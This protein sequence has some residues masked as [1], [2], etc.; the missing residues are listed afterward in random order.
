VLT[1]LSNLPHRAQVLLFL[2]LSL[3][4][5]GGL[6][7][8]AITASTNSLTKEV[9]RNLLATS[10]I[11]ADNVRKEM[12]GL[13][14]VTSSFAS[15]PFLISALGHGRRARY[16]RRDIRFNLQQLLSLR[17]GIGTAF[18]ADPAGRLIDIVPAS[19]AIVGKSF[20]FRDWYKGV[21]RTNR[22][23]VSEVYRS[24]ATGHP[25]VVGVA[26]PI[27]D[28]PAPGAK[29]LGILVVGYRVAAIGRL[30]QRSGDA[31]HLKLTVTDQRGVGLAQ[32]GPGSGDPRIRA[33][34]AGRSGVTE[35]G[36]EGRRVLAAHAPVEGLGW[37]V[38]TE[39]LSAS[40]LADVHR[41]RTFVL[42]VS[43][44]F[45]L[46]LV[47][48][49]ALLNLALRERHRAVA[50]A[51]AASQAKSDFLAN[52]SHEIRTP[53]NGVIGMT[54][55][56]MSTHLDR[57][58]REYAA[59]ARRSGEALLSV[60][61]EILDFSKIEAGKLEL[62]LEPF[63]L[64]E[65][66]A[67]VCD[68]TAAR[69][70][71]K[72][73]ELA[74]AI[75]DCVPRRVRGDRGRLSQVLTNLLTNAVKFTAEGEVVLRVCC[76]EGPREPP[77]VRFEVSDTGIGLNERQRGRIFDSFTQ[78]DASTT[79]RFGGTGLGL[80]ISRDIVQEMGGEIGV[81]SEPGT[82]STFWLNVPLERAGDVP[83]TH[84]GD[85]LRGMRVLIVDDNRTNREILMRQVEALGM[86]SEV[87]ARGREALEVATHASESGEPFDLAIL[88]MHMPEMDGIE[89]ARRM[90]RDPA[91]RAIR[92]IMLTSG[93]IA[94]VAPD[95]GIRRRLRKPVRQSKLFDTI[96]EVVVGG[97]SVADL[98][99]PDPAEAAPVLPAAGA[100]RIL[101]VEDNEVNQSV[102]VA[103]LSRRGYA[104]DVAANG[105]EALDALDEETYDVVLMDCQMPVLDG[106]AATRELRR[107]E[108]AE[109]H[110]PVIAMTANVLAGEREK[111]LEAGMDDYLSKP[112]RSELLQQVLVAHLGDRP[113][114]GGAAAQA[115]HPSRPGAGPVDVERVRD[116]V[117]GFKGSDG[118][119]VVQSVVALY[120]EQAPQRLDA[121]VRAA[122]DGDAEALRTAAHALRGSSSALGAVEVEGLCAELER[123][124]A[125]GDLDRVVGLAGQ[126]ED[127][128][129]RTVPAL[130]AALAEV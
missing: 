43:V 106:Y 34:L 90:Q 84:D 28:G 110:T 3:G 85:A 128:V 73:L 65:A 14:D 71:D 80:T 103:M 126:L 92:L 61:D 81:D 42:V 58:Q 69:A 48:G 2:V 112:L 117:A 70:G 130:R 24:A 93:Q 22:P 45:A 20:A 18:V 116:L 74:L 79:R 50:Q 88:D 124:A 107:R 120:V 23:Y 21:R 59:I 94:P 121:V 78:A 64:H 35:T 108:G 127:A 44:L 47:L 89:L 129:A 12:Q 40:A 19:P 9:R 52:M 86:V 109:R 13:T 10:T 8:I 63:D 36:V 38:I 39:V 118:A 5:L 55:L 41:L 82:G 99:L 87:A 111:T 27:R 97:A 4:P 15:R 30:A 17:P 66:V 46:I 51:R 7:L 83:S 62:E 29:S 1:R 53:M 6:A 105:R 68:L 72:E 37:A 91:L 16:R 33:A 123:L 102:A 54:D 49:V 104:V 11:T 26:V 95:A 119:D 56:L 32:G 31:Q 100:P 75:D 25:K 67:D 76:V 115:E 60:V 122:R 96:A 98:A 101:V 114:T 113:L 57:E 125:A 77:L